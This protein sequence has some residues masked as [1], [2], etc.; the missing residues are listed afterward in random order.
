VTPRLQAADGAVRDPEADAPLGSR[1]SAPARARRRRWGLVAVAALVLAAVVAGLTVSGDDGRRAA[2]ETPVGVP[3]PPWLSGAAGDGV[4]SGEFGA[5]RGRDVEIAGTWA[6][7]NRS[8]TALWTLQP[9]ADLADW[10]KPLDIAVGAIG[11]GETWQE[12]AEG[13]YDARWRESL[14]G[15]RDLWGSRTATLYIRFAHEMNGDWYAWSV[16][17]GEADAF[18]QAWRRFRE[19]QQEIFPASQL[20]FCVNRETVGSDVD[21][22]DLFPGEQ[23]VDLMGVDYYNQHPWV[24]TDE[25]WQ[26][27]IQEVDGAGAPKGLQAHL[28]FAESVGL[29]LAVP[30]W[31]GNADGGDSPAFIEG[32]HEFFA[33]RAGDG[34]GEIVYEIQFNV[35]VDDRNWLLFGDTRMPESAEAYRRLW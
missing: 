9:G 19:M 26:A 16:D 10:D 27:S 35:D 1:H 25:E 2:T 13:A 24:G 20:V 6:D 8:M 21:W 3:A 7:D 28:D 22:R 17:P 23:Y 29:P 12:A 31:S 15:L 18:V 34:V 5:W 30:E 33:T 4:V 11:E 32:M 14:T